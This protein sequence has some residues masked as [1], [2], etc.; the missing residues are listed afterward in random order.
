MNSLL[1]PS[2]LARHRPNGQAKDAVHS[3]A[4]VR[5][6]PCFPIRATPSFMDVKCNCAGSI[7][8]PRS[9]QGCRAL[10]F[11]CAHHPTASQ[12]GPTLSL[13]LNVV[14]QGLATH[15]P[16]RPK[17]AVHSPASVR[18]ILLWLSNPGQHHH[19]FD[20]RCNCAGS[21]HTPHG[22]LRMPCTPLRVCAPPHRFPFGANT[23]SAVKWNCRLPTHTPW[24]AQGCRALPL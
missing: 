24:S 13:L 20:G 2:L 12:S 18:T 19:S 4:S 1:V 22:R 8:P 3:P 16:S 15:P 7:T 21:P 5:T 6:I 9:A 14:M 23:V 17:D 11:E 10:P